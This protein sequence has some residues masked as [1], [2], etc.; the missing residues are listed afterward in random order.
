MKKI[1]FFFI[2][3]FLSIGVVSAKKCT[4]VSGTGNDIGDEIDCAGEPFRIAS[5][6]DEEVVLYAKYNLLVGNK[7]TARDTCAPIP[8]TT[9]NYGMQSSTALGWNF[10][11][12]PTI[13]VI[14]FSET[15]YWLDSTGHFKEP[16]G[17]PDIGTS[18][19]IY[20]SN[21]LIYVHIE[22]YKNALIERG[23]NVLGTKLL[24]W[25]EYYA[26][27]TAA[28]ET[29]HM[30]SWLN[31]ANDDPDGMLSTTGSG[32]YRYSNN[33]SVGIRPAIIV[34]KDDITNQTSTTD[35]EPEPEPDPNPEP[36][37]QNYNIVTQ[38]DGNGTISTTISQA[39]S[40][41]TVTFTV[42]PKEGYVLGVV[43]VT[44]SEGNVITFTDYTFTM[45]TS[46]VTIEATFT[47]QQTNPKTRDIAIFAVL[48][49]LLLS[50]IIAI[51]TKRK[52]QFL[53]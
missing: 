51:A 14:P 9:A 12:Y 11:D 21:S 28:G 32:M 17:A 52:L 16:Y 33:D 22:N 39:S 35:P 44:D 15:V 46:D 27:R 47:V 7:C 29:M 45:P 1:L 34:S 42:S 25:D 6:S 8:T 10:R 2:M 3:L 53:K 26:Y 18:T 37:P 36:E 40:G 38:T 23:I 24:S 19:N 50:F 31:T 43:K 48:T 13:G 49:L 41:E 20:D 5:T 4:I 30:T